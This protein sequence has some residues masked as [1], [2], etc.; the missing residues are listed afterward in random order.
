MLWGCSTQGSLPESW[1]RE[2]YASFPC[3]QGRTGTV[4]AH[5]A[6]FFPLSPLVSGTMDNTAGWHLPRAAGE[7]GKQQGQ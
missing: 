4:V 2:V 6:F 7:V 1:Q 5:L 3:I